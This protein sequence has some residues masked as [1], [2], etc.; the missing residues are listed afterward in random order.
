[1]N[2]FRSKL[3]L[4]LTMY[5]QRLSLDLTKQQFSEKKRHVT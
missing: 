4:V 2:K 1:M 3:K 5:S